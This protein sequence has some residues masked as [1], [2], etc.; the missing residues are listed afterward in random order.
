MRDGTD[1]AAAGNPAGA[2]TAFRRALE[3]EPESFLAHRYLASA[4]L[5]L[6]SYDDA[7][8][9]LAAAARL[10]PQEPSVL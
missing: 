4:L 5:Q 6:E 3:L 8:T 7:L 9:M 10:R 1:A 2:I